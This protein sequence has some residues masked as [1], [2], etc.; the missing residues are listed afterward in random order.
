MKKFGKKALSML[1][2]ALMV[3]SVMPMTKI[4]AEAAN[5]YVFPVTGKW[6]IS[7]RYG[8]RTFNGV[9]S[10]HYGVDIA[11]Y[12]NPVVATAS[13]TVT[14]VTNSCSHVSCGYKCEH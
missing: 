5:K 4:E 7:S 3:I 6:S 10:H 14:R 13:G 12:L 1:L 8:D 9:T 11:A 2:V